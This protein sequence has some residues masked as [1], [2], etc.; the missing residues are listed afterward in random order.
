MT[1]VQIYIHDVKI[2]IKNVTK[3]VGIKYY[4]TFYKCL[5]PLTAG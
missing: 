2:K 5:M 4:F 3:T 1:N